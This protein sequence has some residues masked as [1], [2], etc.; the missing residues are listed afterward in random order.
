MDND[1]SEGNGKENGPCDEE[2]FLE[3]NEGETGEESDSSDEVSEFEEVEES[4]PTPTEAFEKLLM[5]ENVSDILE[6][7]NEYGEQY[8]EA[9]TNCM[10][11]IPRALA[12]GFLYAKFR[13]AEIYR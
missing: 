5:P 10:A 6:E 12:H 9:N 11:D 13:L 1:Q 3:D 4:Q 7:T 8:V 2:I